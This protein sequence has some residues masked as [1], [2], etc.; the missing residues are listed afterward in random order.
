MSSPDPLKMSVRIDIEFAGAGSAPKIIKLSDGLPTITPSPDIITDP[1][2]SLMMQSTDYTVTVVS[3][4]NYISANG[5]SPV[6]GGQYANLAMAMAYPNPNLNPAQYQYANPPSGAVSDTPLGD[7]TWSFTAT[8]YNLVPGSG[9][10]SI[11]GGANNS[12]LIVWYSYGGSPPQF[13]C[14]DST[15]YHGY[16]PA[17]LAQRRMV[18]GPSA[19]TPATLF[20]TFSGALAAFGSL[21]L[22]RN[23]ECW[24]ATPPGAG[25]SI[26]SFQPVGS[27]Y[28]LL[29]SGPGLTFAVAGQ[30]TSNAPFNWSGKGNLPGS[31]GVTVTE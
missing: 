31:F 29:L 14:Q 7:G 10:D 19:G 2:P 9:A 16:L 15:P 26:L 20:A 28:A 6:V 24:F 11:V 23:G 21:A 25:G 8:K 1:G 4:V 18:R 22:N 13:T 27:E 12:T 5:K 3:G 17:G 30:T